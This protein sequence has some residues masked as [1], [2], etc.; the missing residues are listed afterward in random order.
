M[1]SC[2]APA[3]SAD[4]QHYQLPQV[5]CALSPWCGERG[6]PTRPQSGSDV[7][8]GARLSKG[9]KPA[10]EASDQPRGPSSSPLPRRGSRGLGKWPLQWGGDKARCEPC[11][12]SRAP[13]PRAIPT[14]R[15]GLRSP[16][17]RFSPRASG[18]PGSRL[19]LE[20]QREALGGEDETAA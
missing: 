17:L 4:C 10:E 12:Q 1:Q 15:Q 13:V 8:R 2:R 3:S 16:L 20:T 7:Y 14:T 19:A 6:L 9:R 11:V 18:R 5:C